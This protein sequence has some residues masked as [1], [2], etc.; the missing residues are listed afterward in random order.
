MEIKQRI[1]FSGTTHREF[2]KF[3][4]QNNIPFQDGEPTILEITNDTPLKSVVESYVA[5]ND[6]L[7][8]SETLFSKA[9]V[10]SAEWLS[11]RSQWRNGYPQPEEAFAYEDITYTRSGFCQECGCGLVQVQPF[12]LKKEPKWG[13][14]H[15][16]MLN[17][18][19][20]EL[21]MS[22]HARNVFQETYSSD[23]HFFPVNNKGGSESLS[24]VYQLVVPFFLTNGI[25]P[26]SPAINATYQCKCCGK[27]KYHLSG[28][29]M[30]EFKKEIFEG[31]PDI[32][33][34]A[35]V[36][37]WGKSA[38]HQILIRQRLYRFIVENH[39]ERGLVF[40]PISMV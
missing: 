28:M 7:C 16:M 2:V 25:N 34:T 12:R 14:R 4:V 33:K 17:W 21:F 11:L 8:T 31:V 5:R 3:L 13:K 10:E 36:F 6:L 40:E 22:N 20:D 27:R 35:E 9:E 15:F 29:G 32:V 1:V 30:L 23:L 24:D 19:D 18:V 38:S 39:L 37:G 26:N